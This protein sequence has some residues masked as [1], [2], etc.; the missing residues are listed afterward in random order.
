MHSRS[1]R[2]GGGGRG[3][4]GW[5]RGEPKHS[6][7]RFIQKGVAENN[8]GHGIFAAALLELG[9]ARLGTIGA[10]LT[11]DPQHTA[12]RPKVAVLNHGPIHSDDFLLTAGQQ[13]MFL[14]MHS[15]VGAQCFQSSLV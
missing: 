7:L 4:G 8:F 3:G 13:K 14:S 9:L 15:G 11:V 5:K 2:G 10:H 6:A 1:S 12:A